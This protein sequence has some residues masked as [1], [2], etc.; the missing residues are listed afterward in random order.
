MENEALN[1]VLAAKRFIASRSRGSW[2]SE[3][4]FKRLKSAVGRYDESVRMLRK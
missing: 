1:V 2:S 4:G 3:S